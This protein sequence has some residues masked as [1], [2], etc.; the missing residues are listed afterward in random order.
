MTMVPAA[1]R[2]PRPSGGRKRDGVLSTV[3]AAVSGVA[4]HVLH[5]IG[6]LAGVAILGGV[7]GTTLFGVLGLAAS[8]PLLLRMRRHFGTWSAPAIALALFAAMFSVSA[9]VI[10]P[11]IA[12]T[13]NEPASQPGP[14]NHAAHHGG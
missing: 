5:H 10:G 3:I 13:A 12:G 2:S 4:P 11:A 14:T 7:A 6:L 8:V 1:G 9:F